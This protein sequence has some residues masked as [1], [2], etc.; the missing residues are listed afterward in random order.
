MFLTTAGLPGQ[1][2]NRLTSAEAI[3][4]FVMDRVELTDRL[5]VTMG[6][7]YETYEIT[8]DDFST[9]DPT[10]ANGPTRTRVADSSILLPSVSALFDL[11]DNLT[12][13]GG[14][15][16][17][18]SPIGA[19]DT[20]AED[21]IAW[22]YEFGGRYQKGDLSVEVIA[23]LNDYEN[24]LGECTN[25]TGSFCSAGQ[26]FNGG[27]FEARGLEVTAEW[28]AS[29][30]FGFASIEVPVGLAYTFTETEFQTSFDNAFFGDV[31]AGDEL[32][33]V[34]DHQ[35]NLNVG[36]IADQ[37][38]L[39]SGISAVS[40]ARGTIGSGAVLSDDVID[41]RTLV[42][43]SAWYDL[44]D[45]LRLRIQAENLFDETYISA[46]RPA[47]LRPGKPREVLIGF[48]LRF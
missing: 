12:L 2:T 15:H 13:L 46:R 33:Y 35:L 34:P 43:A 18:F 4:A 36:L 19:T 44:T 39:H 7:R 5:S 29:A 25:S 16:K 14:V 24:L 9:S 20:G 37:W 31:D 11:T 6:A 26:A 22:N 45:N 28:D 30:L 41:G 1:T 3:S 21:E 40:E 32:N 8:R 23:Y 10:R 42:D 17:G 38:G 47:G 48:A 27:E